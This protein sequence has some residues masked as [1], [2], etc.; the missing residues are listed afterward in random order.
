M[1]SERVPA[2]PCARG[3]K[4]AAVGAGESRPG[5]WK[6]LG[7]ERAGLKESRGVDRR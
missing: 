3:R 7:A 5:T 1:G 4:A 2:E 6:T